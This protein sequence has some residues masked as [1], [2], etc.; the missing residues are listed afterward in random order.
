MPTLHGKSSDMCANMFVILLNK[1][2]MVVVYRKTI[3]FLVRCKSSGFIIVNS[4]SR[5]VFQLS[6]FSSTF[7]FE[8]SFGC[9][10][11][12][13][14]FWPC[15]WEN[16]Q[17][18]FK[19]SQIS[20]F[21]YNP[22]KSGERTKQISNPPFWGDVSIK[23]WSPFVCYGTP[24]V[25]FLKCPKRALW[26]PKQNKWRP[27]FNANILPKWWISCLIYVYTTFGWGL[28]PFWDLANVGLFLAV[29][30]QHGQTTKRAKWQPKESSNKKKKKINQL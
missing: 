15:C 13:K 19:N 4:I 1:I 28:S 5:K 14:F 25:P 7:W 23:K 6:E 30:L 12:L 21:A 3:V 27:L 2:M 22:S 16:N 18:K 20:K 24:K 17:K 26:V 8:L 9:H 10:L 29:F 11:A